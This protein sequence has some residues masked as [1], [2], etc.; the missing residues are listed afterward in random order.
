[1]MKKTRWP[2]RPR[3]RAR[4]VTWSHTIPA[5][6]QG[7]VWLGQGEYMTRDTVLTSAV[8]EEDPPGFLARVWDRVFIQNLPLWAM[9]AAGLIFLAMMAVAILIRAHQYGWRP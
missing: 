7:R 3:R 9:L 1:M 6:D 2:R 8:E 5:D 4:P